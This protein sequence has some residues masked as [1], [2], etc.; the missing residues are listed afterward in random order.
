MCL[1][2]KRQASRA[3]QNVILRLLLQINEDLLIPL[4]TAESKQD[5]ADESGQE[6]CDSGIPFS[7]RH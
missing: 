6:A 2:M 7:P 4:R 1:A 3:S 5:I